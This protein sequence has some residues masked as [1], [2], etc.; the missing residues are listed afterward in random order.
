M[1]HRPVTC[2]GI[3]IV[4]QCGNRFLVPKR[5]AGDRV[6]CTLCGASV[7]VPAPRSVQQAAAAALAANGQN[8]S[9]KEI[10]ELER[11]AEASARKRVIQPSAKTEPH[12]SD[13]RRRKW[14]AAGM[15]AVVASALVA[16]GGAAVYRHWGTFGNG[17]A[18]CTLPSRAVSR[19]AC[20]PG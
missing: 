12:P 19:C 2:Q 10:V 9:W 1:A 14:I 4:C 18:A 6:S 8:G 7:P 5:Q 16:V 17:L 13:P 11:K 15:I 3:L 20:R